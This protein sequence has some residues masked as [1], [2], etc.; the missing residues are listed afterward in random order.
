M[1]ET[2]EAKMAET[3]EDLRQQRAEVE[4]LRCDCLSAGEGWWTL[5]REGY[6]PRT[7]V[8]AVARGEGGG[9]RSAQAARF[10][11]AALVGFL[12]G[13]FLQVMHACHVSTC[14]HL[15]ALT[16]RMP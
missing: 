5:V 2:L 7:V 15:H 13:A 10:T 11:A 12:V 8:A 9:G 16:V 6:W 4:A 3:D 1:Q 14:T